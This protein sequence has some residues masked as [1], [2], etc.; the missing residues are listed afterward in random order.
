MKLITIDL[1]YLESF[2]FAT[3][4]RLDDLE[5]EIR[6]QEKSV[7]NLISEHDIEQYKLNLEKNDQ[8]RNILKRTI[9]ELQM[10]HMQLV[11]IRDNI[12]SKC[13]N[14]PGLEKE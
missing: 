2:E 13:F 10:N 5:K 4:E 6:K 11:E 8:E 12:P 3:V 7:E 14:E 9:H 1:F